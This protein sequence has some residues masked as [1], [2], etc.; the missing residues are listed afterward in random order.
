M[1]KL[2]IAALLVSSLMGVVLPASAK[3]VN[4]GNTDIDTNVGII[5]QIQTIAPVNTAVL[6]TAF[7]DV[8]RDTLVQ[9]AYLSQFIH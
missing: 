7:Q 2:L 8:S 9:I 1:K 3:P 4:V 5:T 6:G